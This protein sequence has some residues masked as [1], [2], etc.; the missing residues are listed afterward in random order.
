MDENERE[1]VLQCRRQHRA[2]VCT[3]NVSSEY[4]C[5]ASRPDKK[6]YEVCVYAHIVWGGAVGRDEEKKKTK[7]KKKTS[8]KKYKFVSAGRGKAA[9][10]NWNKNHTSYFIRQSNRSNSLI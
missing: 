2:H 10:L 3:F 1:R 7:E 4:V 9:V 8:N 5:V 6:F